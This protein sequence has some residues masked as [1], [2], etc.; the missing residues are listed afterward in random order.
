[1]DLGLI[2]LC[3]TC[4]MLVWVIFLSYKYFKVMKNLGNGDSLDKMLSKYI[5]EVNNVKKDNNEI[6]EEA[7]DLMLKYDIDIPIVD[8][9]NNN[10]IIAKSIN[11]DKKILKKIKQ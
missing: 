4:V 3:I 9:S 10:K 11:L 8:T 7:M 2:S 6:N 1:M 5:T